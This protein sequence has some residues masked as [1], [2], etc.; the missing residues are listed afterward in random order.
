[1]TERANPKP[2]LSNEGALSLTFLGVGSAF[3]KK[4]HQ[5][6]LLIVKGG[7]H[8]LVDC[9][10]RGPEAL[11]SLGIPV[12]KLDNFLITHSH[13]DHIGGLE[14]VM[15]MD[16]Y[17]AHKKPSIIITQEYQELLWGS[18]LRGGATFNERIDGR[19][20]E[21][22]DYWTVER[23]R[24]VKGR[25]RFLDAACGSIGI[26]MFRTMHYPD[27]A[28]SWEDSA[29][30]W[31]LI[32]DGKVLFSSDT[33][34]DPE[35]IQG[36]DD[37]FHFQTIFHDCQFFTGGVHASLEELGGLPQAI[38]A[39]MILVHYGDAAEEKRGRVAELGFAGLGEQWREYLFP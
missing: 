10:T 19:Y 8:L 36:L 34:F 2:S 17:M 30:S 5:T 12:T 21:F 27:S 31:G 35:L 32:L 39:R 1:M 6:N 4:Y 26:R 9:G 33:R 14:E 29:L 37:E 25:L 16:R 15:L 7:S 24:P 11:H 3:T 23:P 22:E 18:S 28:S 20:L 13:A 38:K